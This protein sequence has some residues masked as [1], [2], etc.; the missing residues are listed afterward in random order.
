MLRYL[1][2]VQ[3][4]PWTNGKTT[5][6]KGWGM[7][8]AGAV[9]R[10]LA[11]GVYAMHGGVSE[12]S[13]PRHRIS[14]GRSQLFV[15]PLEEGVITPR[16][17]GGV[18]VPCS[19]LL[20]IPILEEAVNE[21]ALFAGA[22][23]GILGGHLLGWRTVCAVEVDPYARD[24]LLARQN[25]GCLPP[26]PVW[27]DVR[28]FDGRPWRG[29][30]DVVSG[31]FPCQD[32]S[33]N[34]GAN[35]KGLAGDKSGLWREMA[36]IIGEVRP[37]FAFVENSPALTFRGLGRVLG[38][39]AELGFDAAWGVFSAADVG[40][41]HR[42]ERIWIAAWNAD[43]GDDRARRCLSQRC[44]DTAGVSAWFNA[45]PAVGRVANGVALAMDRNGCLGNGQVPAVVALAWRILSMPNKGFNHKKGC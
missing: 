28:T 4:F 6:D 29:A 5:A 25:D 26:F 1:L 19:L 42:R 32:I 11:E 40:A 14:P 30:V 43:E 35:R 16:L 18:A 21:L 17:T 3:A 39:L 13:A 24:V 15:L 44:P 22:G 12:T 7:Y 23:G 20:G 41:R 9:A 33:T 34:G 8:L 37:R 38:D 45:E 2:M 36:R 27:D 10:S 31:G